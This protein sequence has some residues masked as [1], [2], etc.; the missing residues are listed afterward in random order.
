[1]RSKSP[2]LSTAGL[3]AAG[4]AALTWTAYRRD[5]AEA[6]R[7]IENGRQCIDTPEGV[8]EFGESGD[9]PAAL[10]IH[11]AGGGFD[12]GLTLGRALLGD[13]WRVVAPS[14]FGYLGTPLPLNASASAQADAHRHLLD[15]LQLDA[16][17]VIGISAGAPSAMQ[18]CV[19]HPERCTSL[20][21]VVPLAWAPNRKLDEGSP[22]IAAML[23]AITRSDFVYWSAMRFARD[24]M[25]GTILGTP[26]DIYHAAAPDERKHADQILEQMLPVS[27]RAAGIRNDEIVSA[28]LPR[29][30]LENI[31]VP[32]LV[33]SSADDG[34]RT[35]D[36]ALYASE[37]IPG[38]EFAGYQTGG[39]LLMGHTADVRAHIARFLTRSMHAEATAVS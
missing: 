25:I 28:T 38:G 13:A 31:Q 29:F 37:L 27:R 36:G 26:A 20:V 11:G 10:V 32:A 1:M 2:V 19:R 30:P 34:Y 23:H 5:L 12:Q 4:A 24:S 6:R 15:A 22:L 16:V 7:R 9:G 3:V 33:F 39:H 8:I 21:L 14:R 35:Y 18:L 17:P